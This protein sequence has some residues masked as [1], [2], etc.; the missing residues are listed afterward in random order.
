MSDETT[1]R[2]GVRPAALGALG[3][4]FD[5]HTATAQPAR[6]RIEESRRA[7]VIELP[8]QHV[9]WPLNEV[10]QLPDQATKDELV[11]A[12]A[13]D[14]VARLVT[15]EMRLAQRFPNLSRRHSHVKRS[16]VARWALMALAAVALIIFVLVPRMADQLANFIPP[17]GE[18]ALGDA[19]LG[20]IRSAL[21]GGD[22]FPIATCE[23]DAGQAALSKIEA[24]LAVHAQL[25]TP[26]TVHVLDHEMVNAFALPGGHVVFFDGLLQA[27][28]TPEEFASVFAHE[29]GHVVSRDPTRHALR[30]AGSIGVLGLLFGDFAGGA[31]VLFLTE[32]LIDAQYSQAAE[33]G[34]DEFALTLMEAA[35]VPPK[36]L[37]DMFDR[38]RSLYG[39][40]DGTTAHFLSHPSLGR[41]ID[42][43]EVWQAEAEARGFIAAPLLS[44]TEWQALK[45]I[46]R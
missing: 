16:R 46:C 9:T 36:A 34:A 42:R 33:S 19:T 15:D 29:I 28:E 21:G 32:R 6:L 37:G 30:S 22:A 35:S 45:A 43:A 26:L 44:D 13:G 3:T 1:I 41:R 23:G 10:R 17:E 24:R 8:G 40:I 4:Y 14:P 7:L 20:Q 27:A 5:G 39:D 12:R 2:V 31:L 18:K 25:Q 11:L 38:F